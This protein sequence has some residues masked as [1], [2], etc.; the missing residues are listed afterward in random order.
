[1]V[2]GLVGSL[3]DFAASVVTVVLSTAATIPSAGASVALGV[4]GVVGMS[5]GA[6]TSILSIAAVM[7]SC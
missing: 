3:T 7:D 2:A 4:A 5:A 1:M 6:V